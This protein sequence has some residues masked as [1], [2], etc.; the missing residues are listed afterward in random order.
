[1]FTLNQP[2]RQLSRP[3][4]APAVQGAPAPTEPVSWLLQVCPD[5]TFKLGAR[6]KGTPGK[7][8]FNMRAVFKLDAT[9][10]L[11]VLD[12]VQQL[13]I[14]GH[15]DMA[16]SI[17][18][19]DGPQLCTVCNMVLETFPRFGEFN[20]PKW[21]IEAFIYVVLKG[22]TEK[23]KKLEKPRVAPASTLTEDKQAAQAATLQAKT[24]GDPETIDIDSTSKV[25]NVAGNISELQIGGEVGAEP[26]V[27]PPT[28]AALTRP[29]AH[30]PAHT[31]AKA[32]AAPVNPST[33]PPVLVRPT[34]H[35]RPRSA[36]PL[37]PA[38]PA[39]P[40]GPTA[41]APPSAPAE[42]APPASRPT[43]PAAEPAPAAP[44]QSATH[45]PTGDTSSRTAGQPFGGSLTLASCSN[46]V[47]ARVGSVFLDLGAP[48]DN[49]DDEL[50]EAPTELESQPVTAGKGKGKATTSR[51]AG[52]GK[53]SGDGGV[54]TM[55]GG[56]Q[57]TKKK[58]ANQ[59]STNNPAPVATM[60]TQC[61][62]KA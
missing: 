46:A 45:P 9:D 39:E 41:C 36:T 33:H 47:L 49:D 58:V 56:K 44:T 14:L 10:Y 21:P 42:P 48:D 20:D 19:Q 61:A 40:T 11:S 7:A 3:A 5:I 23:A 26:P 30:T 53:A 22:S 62:K 29:T 4:Q 55:K 8:Q 54:A 32:V 17:S 51:G 59:A 28:G 27:E 25:D 50:S 1:M 60:R 24:E 35:P 13:C 52:G 2:G 15:L 18:F 34:P 6:P 31:P 12:G 43:P 37:D 57:G 16:K 38:P